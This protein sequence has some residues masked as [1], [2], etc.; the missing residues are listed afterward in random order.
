MAS[1][2]R[3]DPPAVAFFYTPGGFHVAANIWAKE[4][5]ANDGSEGNPAVSQAV[6]G[7]PAFELVAYLDDVE[8]IDVALEVLKAAL[9]YE[10]GY[11]LGRGTVVP[12]RAVQEAIIAAFGTAEAFRG[13]IV[14]HVGTPRLDDLP[15]QGLPVDALG[16]RYRPADESAR[17]ER[18]PIVWVDTDAFDRGTSGHART[19]NALAEHLTCRHAAA[20]DRVASPGNAQLA[21]RIL[22]LLKR[23]GD[24]RRDSLSGHVRC[25]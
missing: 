19:Q 1:W 23:D 13:A 25:S 15:A 16:T 12:S 6:W 21:T 5:A 3:V 11:S 2:R 18:S 4:P 22:G 20:Q 14:G 9:G 8:A 24:V 17:P 10:A 7:D